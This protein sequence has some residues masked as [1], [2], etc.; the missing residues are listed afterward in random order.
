MTPEE[1]EATRLTHYEHSSGENELDREA[2]AEE[3]EDA[4]G[5]DAF[6]EILA[7]AYRMSQRLPG[8]RPQH[9]WSIR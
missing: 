9:K 5:H 3:V 6:Q 7:D 8:I 4:L 2:T 1:I